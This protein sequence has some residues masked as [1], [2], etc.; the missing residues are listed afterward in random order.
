MQLAAGPSQAARL[1]E[2]V[3]GK[4][5]KDQHPQPPTR[6]LKSQDYSSFKLK[7]W[8]TWYHKPT[9]SFS[10][11][12]SNPAGLLASLHVRSA[13][14]GTA[15]FTSAWATQLDEGLSSFISPRNLQSDNI[16]RMNMCTSTN[17]CTII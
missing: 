3:S 15:G 17:V 16:A 2:N 9:E 14:G 13:A 11:V 5:E 12:L 7:S 4:F 1:Q 8:D 10:L 6:L